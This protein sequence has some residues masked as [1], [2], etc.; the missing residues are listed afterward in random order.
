[1]TRDLLLGSALSLGLHLALVLGNWTPHKNPLLQSAG[2]RGFKVRF[3]VPLFTPDEP[4]VIEV[5]GTDAAPLDLA[6]PMQPDRPQPA[7]IDAFVQ[8][9]QP[10]PPEGVTISA[11]MT[12]VPAVRDPRAFGGLTVFDVTML[13]QTPV[14]KL[15]AAPQ[16]PFEMRRNGISGDVV[17]DFIV[18]TR[19]EV[20][21]AF[22]LRSTHREF[23]AAAVQAVSKWRFRPG[24]KDGRDVPTHMQV[25]IV[26]R[27][28]EL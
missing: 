9:V 22:A 28:N 25:P 1:M 12:V 2:D 14:P 5:S 26:F 4:E 20:Q 3:E 19:G 7:P 6:P 27:L 13:D 16:Y 10:P 21:S 15:Q 17:V 8:K 24:R 18:D 23:E 11:T